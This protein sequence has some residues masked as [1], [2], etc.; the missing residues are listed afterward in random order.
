MDEI[1]GFDINGLQVTGTKLEDENI[2]ALMQVTRSK[3]K[4]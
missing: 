3:K 4:D 1:I 2:F